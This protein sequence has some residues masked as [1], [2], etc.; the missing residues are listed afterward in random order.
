MAMKLSEVQAKVKVCTVEWDDETVDVG[1]CPA[2]FT[3]EVLEAVTEAEGEGNLSILGKML[4]P[5]LDW[6]DVL[7]DKDKRLP[8]DAATIARMPLA[9]VMKVLAELQADM[10]PP[11]SKD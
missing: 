1:Y 5:V 11:A 7:D 9:F 3:A 10:N 6:W 8:T 4:E 2:R